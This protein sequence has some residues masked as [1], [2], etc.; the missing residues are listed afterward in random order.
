MTQT[1]KGK[2]RWPIT[3]QSKLN[4]EY[5]NT[6]TLLHM[7]TR[8]KIRPHE[9][10]NAEHVYGGTVHTCGSGSYLKNKKTNCT[11]EGGQVGRNM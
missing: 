11:T 1:S 8:E 2:I 5:T 9:T 4:P 6:P 3:K 10:V 7:E